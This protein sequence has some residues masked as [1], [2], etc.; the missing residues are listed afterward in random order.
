MRTDFIIKWSMKSICCDVFCVCVF[1]GPTKIHKS[2]PFSA[3]YDRCLWPQGMM[4]RSY[5]LHPLCQ[6]YTAVPELYTCG[7]C[8]K[9]QPRNPD[10]R[11]E[12][13]YTSGLPEGWWRKFWPDYRFFVWYLTLWETIYLFAAINRIILSSLDTEWISGKGILLVK[14]PKFSSWQRN[15]EFL[16]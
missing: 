11:G 4:H 7:W 16:H 14:Q 6:R 2:P 3:R 15:Q 13:M 8:T 10:R 12:Y 9:I 5:H 1:V